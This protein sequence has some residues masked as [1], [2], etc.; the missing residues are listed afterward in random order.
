VLSPVTKLTFATWQVRFADITIS[1]HPRNWASLPSKRRHQQGR[2]YNT[3]TYSRPT[4]LLPLRC[5][6]NNLPLGIL[7]TKT[8]G[9]LLSR[10][11]WPSLVTIEA[12]LPRLSKRIDTLYASAASRDTED[13]YFRA[14]GARLKLTYDDI[15]AS[16]SGYKL[17]H[18]Q[19]FGAIPK[20]LRL[21]IFYH[22]TLLT[23]PNDA[24]PARIL[25]FFILDQTINGKPSKQY[26]GVWQPGLLTAPSL[27]APT[28]LVVRPSKGLDYN[29]YTSPLDEWES[30]SVKLWDDQILVLRH[31]Q[32]LNTNYIRLSLETMGTSPHLVPAV[33]VPWSRRVD[34]MLFNVFSGLVSSGR[35]INGEA[36]PEIPVQ[37][38]QGDHWSLI[39][40]P[41]R[42]PPFT[43]QDWVRTVEDTTHDILGD[44]KEM[45]STCTYDIADHQRF[46]SIETSQAGM[47]T[48]LLQRLGLKHRHDATRS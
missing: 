35:L 41:T 30:L 36:E 38:K 7:L 37:S 2:D 48:R 18:R 46:S 24:A 9:D 29:L 21:D 19:D 12:V 40:P 42:Y 23:L 32:G 27:D 45:D 47:P 1:R 33:L 39:G 16:E 3:R 10:E 25:C 8:E 31:R 14:P 28:T 43:A 20:T 11:H 4:I 22:N 17:L 5:H 6:H 15:C 44:P 34:T 26:V 13:S